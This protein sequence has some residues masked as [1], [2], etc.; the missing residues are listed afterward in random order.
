[1]YQFELKNILQTKPSVFKKI[2]HRTKATRTIFF[3][4]SDT[5]LISIS[6]LFAF[7][8]RFEGTIP[9]QYLNSTI[10]I[11]IALSILSYSTVFALFK[12]YAFSWIY[13]STNELVNLAKSSTLSFLFLNATFFLFRDFEVFFGFPRSILVI[14]YI[15]IFIFCGGI[16]FSKRVYL[17]LTNKTKFYKDKETT[18]IVGAGDAGEQILRS[19]LISKNTPYMPVGFVDDDQMKQG[20][21]IHNLKIIGTT[22]SIPQIAR[23]QDIENV[24]IALP[25]A[26]SNQIKRA[27]DLSRKAGIKK[28]KVVPPISEL[29]NSE[30]S[31]GNI[32][33]IEIEDLLGRGPIIID[34]KTIEDFIKNKSVLITGAAGSIG[35]ELSRQISKFKPS[36][37]VL[38]DQ[39]ETGIF[40]LSNELNK[41]FQNIKT[42]PIIAD[43]CDEQKIKT[44]FKKYEPNIIFHTA[45]Y[46]HV[47]LMEQNPG[48][49]IKNNIFGTKTVAEAAIQSKAE[50]F[51]F[52]STDKAINPT[53]IMG[54]TKQIGEMLTQS[55]NQKNTTKFMSVRFGNVLGSRGSVIPAFKEQIKQGYV[56]VTHPEMK[57]YF[58]ITSEACLLVMQAAEM[59]KGGEVFVL[60]MG[61][62]VKI[63]DLAKEMIKLS[64]FEPDKD[65][66]VVF[67]GIRPGEKLFEEILTSKEETISTKNQKIFI[68]KLAGTNEERL[69]AG[70]RELKIAASSNDRQRIK[71][72]IHELIP[73]YKL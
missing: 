60:D 42:T 8:I 51:V 19:I 59:G 61:N 57:R 21:I 31:I 10:P 13:I 52:I 62:P 48:E 22:E 29:I 39:D 28:I 3:I 23:D 30:I 18:L 40:N 41:K 50:K 27:V 37:L 44:I 46:K 43:I 66:P 47:P 9:E 16:R 33:E 26:S 38:L 14:S 20:L 54:A 55:L 63:V 34:T 56:E 17:N 7:L 32:R 6:I 45:A 15:L 35:S 73:S 36:N 53:S 68:A 5:I 25:S 12:L 58:M 65:I 67:T 4:A 11:T 71:I 2:F 70:L 1:M 24:I 69:Y 64:G 72:S 49:A